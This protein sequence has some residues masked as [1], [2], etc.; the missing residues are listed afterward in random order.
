M[1]AIHKLYWR[2]FSLSSVYK[3]YIYFV[4]HLYK[5]KLY[6]YS[7]YC[8]KAK[9]RVDTKCTSRYGMSRM[10]VYNLPCRVFTEDHWNDTT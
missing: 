2:L 5:K 6:E 1:D 3:Q 8:V 10:N 7:T 9:S 4:M